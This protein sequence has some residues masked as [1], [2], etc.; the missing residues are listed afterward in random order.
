MGTRQ[1]INITCACALRTGIFLLQQLITLFLNQGPAAHGWG[2][3]PASWTLGPS[4]L[5]CVKLSQ[6]QG[7]LQ[8][9]RKVRLL[10]TLALQNHHWPTKKLRETQCMQ[11][12]DA[13]SELVDIDISVNAAEKGL[14]NIAMLRGVYSTTHIELDRLGVRSISFVGLALI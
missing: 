13:S 4:S 6:L 9:P 7:A 1:A 3:P 10:V 5:A 8:A 14:G 12:V 11:I 2:Q